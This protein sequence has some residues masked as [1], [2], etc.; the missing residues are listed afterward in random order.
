MKRI[1]PTTLFLAAAFFTAG[2]APLCAAGPRQKSMQPADSMRT[3]R[4]EPSAADRSAFHKFAL[5]HGKTWKVR[6]NPRTALPEALTGGRTPR[7]PG[8]PEQ[9]ASAFMNENKDLLKIEPSALRLANSKKFLGMTH[10]QYQQ[11]YNGIPVEFSYA[12]AHISAAGEISGYQARFEPGIDINIIPSITAEQARQAAA[13]DIGRPFRVTGT[14][15]V[16][17]PDEAAGAPKL[18]WKVRG[19]SGGYWIYYVDA[20][21]GALLLKYDDTRRVAVCNGTA[22]NVMGRSSATVYA[23]SPLST[24]DASPGVLQ[25]TWELPISTVI[26]NQ[27]FWVGGPSTYTATN[28]DGDYCINGV[29]GKVY[30]AFKG[31]YFSVTNARGLSAHFDN[32]GGKWRVYN[33]NPW[34]GSGA[35]VNGQDTVYTAVVPSSDYVSLGV[36]MKAVPYFDSFSVGAMDEYGTVNNDD[37]VQVRNDLLGGNNTVASYIAH[38]TQPFHGASVESSTYSLRL[39]ADGADTAGGF[40]IKQSSYMYLPS[41]NNPWETSNITGSVVWSTSSANVYLD[42]RPNHTDGLAEVNAFYHLD[43]ARNFFET[44]N[45]NPY[46][47][48]PKPVNLDKRVPVMVHASGSP[49]NIPYAG[50]L[51]AYYDLVNDNIVIGDGPTD[52]N[53]N[54][55]SFALDGTVVRHEY[56]HLAINRI[57]PIINY[58]EFGALSE[59][60]A[61]YFSL[62]S[63]WREGRPLSILGNFLGSGS[64]DIDAPLTS[65]PNFKKIPDHWNGEVHD[66]AMIISEAM[67]T[68]RNGGA[69]SLGTIPSGTFSGLPVADVIFWSALFY[70]PDN[71]T[72]FYDAAVDACKQLET[73]AAGSCGGAGSPNVSLITTA[74]GAHGIPVPGT[75]GDAYETA[76]NDGLCENNNGPECAAE[77]SGLTSI[78]ATIYPAVDVDYYSLPIAAGNVYATLTLPPAANDGEYK[79]YGMYLFDSKRDIV[80]DAEGNE[81][82]AVPVINDYGGYCPASGDCI[83]LSPSVSFYYPSASAGR[84]YLVVSGGPTENYSNSVVKSTMPY[85]LS[86]SYGQKGAVE[87]YLD[88][89]STVDNDRISF[90]APHEKFSMSMA[91]SSHTLQTA[92]VLFNYAQLRDHNG[93]ALALARTDIANGLLRVVGSTIDNDYTDSLGR[94]MITGTLGVQPGFALRYPGVGTVTVEVFG[95]NHMGKI[96]SLGQSGLINLSTNRTT[97]TTYNNLMGDPAKV[98]HA[99]ANA[100]IKY[101]LQ[102]AGS[103]TIKIYTQAGSLVKTVYDGPAPAGKGTLNWDGTNSNGKKAASGIYFVKAKGAGLDKTDKIAIVR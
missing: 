86:L 78:S 11:Y 34:V 9:A 23:I 69:N 3:V 94:T 26:A 68:L 19:T 51:N 41:A 61:D 22:Y 25:T 102:A 13:V 40:M 100:I 97:M 59:A 99:S 72:N 49:D 31:P 16:I 77:L 17:F 14:E 82:S 62:A 15:L 8:S 27:Y 44:M 93:T 5:K 6:Y 63:F 36:F 43:R 48:T 53:L 79:A 101:E 2:A 42:A 55:R 56:V 21:N 70:F 76:S 88:A 57:Y 54:Y 95:S 39:L 66:D 96:V 47:G 20:A 71:F 74:F 64:R 12:R 80:Y 37:V 50:M 67:Y 89:G 4:K 103:L 87:A 10:I 30:S 83:T 38:H 92:E 60:L 84:Y 46:D 7:Y 65:S 29:N 73:L 45:K 90:M 58:G 28:A 32:G 1:T 33:H 35:Y 52:L 91:P 85:T 18:A 24:G 98:P 81:V 75:A